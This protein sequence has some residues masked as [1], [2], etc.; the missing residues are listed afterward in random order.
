MPW[1]VGLA[2]ALAALPWQVAPLVAV[3]G[4]DPVLCGYVYTRADGLEV[5]VEKGVRDDLVF[6][7]VDA[8]A[9]AVELVTASFDS[10]RDLTAA[11]AAPGRTR[12]EGDLQTVDAGG[13]LF[14]ELAVVGGGLRV[15]RLTAEA[16]GASTTLQWAQDR[17]PA[18]LPRDVT[19]IYLNCAGDLVRP[20]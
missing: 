6:T 16:G 8:S 15:G 14:A 2:A 18:P 9:D 7:A 17:L 10:R 13:A 3:Q 4:S 11:A 12:L 19:A 1:V 20:P 5:R